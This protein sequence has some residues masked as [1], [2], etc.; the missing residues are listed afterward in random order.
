LANWAEIKLDMPVYTSF[1]Q[2]LQNLY[3]SFIPPSHQNISFDSEN[4]KTFCP[5][6]LNF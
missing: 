1:P 5:Y 4:G 6:L 2:S 3:G